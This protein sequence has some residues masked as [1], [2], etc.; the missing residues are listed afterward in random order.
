[1]KLCGINNISDMS[2]MFYGCYH[3]FSVFEYHK[4]KNTQDN[5]ENIFSEDI[6]NLS[7]Y[8]ELKMSSNIKDIYDFFLPDNSIEES[9]SLSLSLSLIRQ[10]NSFNSSD[11]DNNENIKYISLLSLKNNKISNMSYMFTGCI[12][13]IYLSFI[14]KLDIS[15]VKYINS[16]FSGCES[17]K[18]CMTYLIGILL[19]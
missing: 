12:S 17:L 4:G 13:L 19:I 2:Y 6:S 7:L 18:N 16:I 8:E 14:S 10:N 1:M 15:N 9:I 3:L 5:S 11:K